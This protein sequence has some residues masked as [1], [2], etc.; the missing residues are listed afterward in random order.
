M[1]KFLCALSKYCKPKS[2]STPWTNSMF[3]YISISARGVWS[4][5]LPPRALVPSVGA[6][7]SFYVTNPN[8]FAGGFCHV[9]LY[10]NLAQI[11]V[12]VVFEHVLPRYAALRCG[13][14]RD[15]DWKKNSLWCL[16]L[17]L[18]VILQLKHMSDGASVCL[19]LLLALQQVALSNNSFLPPSLFMRFQPFSGCPL[20]PS[21][22]AFW[23]GRNGHCFVFLIA[24]SLFSHQLTSV[25]HWCCFFSVLRCHKDYL[26]V[27]GLLP[28]WVYMYM[29]DHNLYGTVGF[30]IMSLA[31]YVLYTSIYS[32]LPEYLY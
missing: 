11:D 19:L 20:L 23:K 32:V 9:K 30:F 7:P 1:N 31:L 28:K 24:L 2:S 6:A 18:R 26:C 16:L 17:A 4:G 22:L 13:A 21:I 15:P 3:G 8:S 29:N 27:Y 14:W 12:H 5:G 25:I 10:I